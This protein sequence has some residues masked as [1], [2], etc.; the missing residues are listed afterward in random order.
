MFTKNILDEEHACQQH[1]HNDKLH[2]FYSALL[3]QY[4]HG[5]KMSIPCA[6]IASVHDIRSYHAILLHHDH[7]YCELPYQFIKLPLWHEN[8]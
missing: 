1:I 2:V 3:Y 7:T 5:N 8:L 6:F 4:I